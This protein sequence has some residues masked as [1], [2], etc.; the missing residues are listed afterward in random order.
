MRLNKLQQDAIKQEVQI[1]FGDD[2]IVKLF[3]SRVDD[4]LKGGDIDLFIQV[5]KKT[6]DIWRKAL[7][8]NVRLQQ[9]IGEQK[10]DII[11][12]YQRQNLNPIHREA[13]RT[14]IIL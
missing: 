4:T 9:R 5:N 14:G 3:G 1:L 2:A 13:Q 10:I 6:D 7:K 11:T 8:L 12:S